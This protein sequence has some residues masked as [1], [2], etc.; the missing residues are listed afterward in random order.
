MLTPT[1]KDHIGERVTLRARVNEVNDGVVCLSAITTLDDVPVAMHRRFNQGK[2][3]AG[4]S[5]GEYITFNA[6]IR[7][8]EDG[9]PQFKVPNNVAVCSKPAQKY[10]P[11]TDAMNPHQMYRQFGNWA[12]LNP[13]SKKRGAEI[14][15]LIPRCRLSRFKVN[16]FERNRVKVSTYGHYMLHRFLARWRDTDESYWSSVKSFLWHPNYPISEGN[17][18]YVEGVTEDSYFF[19]KH[20]PTP[21]ADY[22][23]FHFFFYRVFNSSPKEIFAS[24]RRGNNFNQW[25]EAQ[26]GVLNK[27]RQQKGLDVDGLW[28]ELQGIAQTTMRRIEDLTLELMN[29]L[30]AWEYLEGLRD[31]SALIQIQLTRMRLIAELKRNSTFALTFSDFADRVYKEARISAQLVTGLPMTQ[32][33]KQRPWKTPDLLI[34]YLKDATI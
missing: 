9:E 24:V 27:L 32:F 34:D 20:M 21:P 1:F 11:Q 16:D 19:Y 17:R 33:P 2:T 30:F 6:R 12:R 3:F 5:A 10:N 8:D 29:Q 23:D 4:L 28:Q 7:V 26:G 14:H 13:R 18:D 22:S 25:I 31:K 15:H